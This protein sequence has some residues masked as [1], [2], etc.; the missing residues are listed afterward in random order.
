MLNALTASMLV[1]MVNNVDEA[2]TQDI[3]NSITGGSRLGVS[4]QAKFGAEKLV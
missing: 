2:I 1:R 3:I 4:E